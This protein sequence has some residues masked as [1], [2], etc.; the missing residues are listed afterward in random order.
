MRA[1][2]RILLA[3]IANLSRS[4]IE[5][6]QTPPAEQTALTTRLAPDPKSSWSESALMLLDYAPYLHT[7]RP[8]RV[9]GR[10]RRRKLR[11]RIQYRPRCICIRAARLQSPL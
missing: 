10:W 1:R 9:T 4:F 11:W 8:L 2:S 5:G 3:F 7:L 6:P